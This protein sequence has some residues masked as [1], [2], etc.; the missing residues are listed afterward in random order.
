[1]PV[2]TLV[3]AVNDGLRQE[4]ARD[5]SVMVL[6][7][8]VGSLGGVF[9]ATNGLLDEFGEDRCVD[10]PLAEAGIVGA[11]IALHRKFAPD[12]LSLPTKPV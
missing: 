6:G 5:E 8:D 4:M 10:T 2:R 7:E 11:A 12:L 9:R 1:M 3:Q